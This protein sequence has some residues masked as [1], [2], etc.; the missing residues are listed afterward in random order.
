MAAPIVFQLQN[1]QLDPTFSSKSYFLLRAVL[2]LKDIT[3]DIPFQISLDSLPKATNGT[4]I[5]NFY[6]KKSVIQFALKYQWF[7]LLF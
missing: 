3:R 4:Q 7:R 2:T 6:K 5:Q 1:F